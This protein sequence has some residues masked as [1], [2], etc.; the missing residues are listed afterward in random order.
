ML[1]AV[2]LPITWAVT[3]NKASHYVGFILP[4]I[5]ELPGSFSGRDNSPN[6]LRGP[7]ANNLISFAIFLQ[8]TAIVFNEPWNSTKASWQAKASNLLGAVSNYNPVYFVISSATSSANPLNVFNPV[9]T[10]V[11]PYANKLTDFILLFTR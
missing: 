10:A 11:P 2:L 6:P 5:I 9:P 4:G 3:I 8:E 7:D 1:T